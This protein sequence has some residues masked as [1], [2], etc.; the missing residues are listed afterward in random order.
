M[1]DEIMN[2]AISN[3]LWAVLFVILFLYQINSSAKREQKYQNV[4]D[5]LS[6]SFGMI[7]N[8]DQNV[9]N[10]TKD[11]DKIKRFFVTKREARNEFKF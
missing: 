4:I 10:V 7:K 5:K 3:G 1:I 11:L 9:K 2:L 8:I 6:N